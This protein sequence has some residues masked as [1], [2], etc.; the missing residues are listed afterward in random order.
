MFR[1]NLSLAPHAA[2]RGLHLRSIAG[3]IVR[4]V[5]CRN[6]IG[7]FDLVLA[8]GVFD[9]LNERHVVI[10]LRQIYYYLLRDGGRLYFSNMRRRNP[11]RLWMS[12]MA[13]WNLIERN[14]DDIRRIACTARI[15]V[16]NLIVDTDPTT[17]SL[18]TV[19]TKRS[20]NDSFQRKD[21]NVQVP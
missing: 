2:I 16:E 6:S 5:R 9:Y 11:Y 17:L 1:F 18:L 8:G 4:T 10:I 20:I 13:D 3:D 15:P 21:S 7:S 19:V 14:E 12:Y